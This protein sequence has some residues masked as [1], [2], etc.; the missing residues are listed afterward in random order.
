MKRLLLFALLL[1]PLTAQAQSP[2]DIF[3]QALRLERSQG[4]LSGAIKLYLQVATDFGGD[5]ALGA[6]ALYRIG[7]AYEQLGETEAKGAYQQIVAEFGDQ[8]ETVA[9]ARE[10]LGRLAVPV[11]G[12]TRYGIEPELVD[13]LFGY[14]GSRF[15]SDGRLF[16]GTN[17]DTNALGYQTVG[18][19]GVSYIT[20]AFED[21]ARNASSASSPRFSP[22]NQK[23]GFVWWDGEEGTHWLHVYD[24]R[25]G[26]TRVLFNNERRVGIEPGSG[27]AYFQ[28][29]DW[30]SD[31]SA[32]LME[33]W[34]KPVTGTVEVIDAATGAPLR[35]MSFDGTAVCLTGDRYVIANGRKAGRAVAVSLDLVSGSASELLAG[36][37][38]SN[39]VAC[40]D[41]GGL[42]VIQSE[43]TGDS[44]TSVHDLVEG[45]LGQRVSNVP[46]VLPDA[47]G[48]GLTADGTLH[49]Y[50][51]TGNR[52]LEA[53]PYSLETWT[54]SGPA[55][56]LTS[57]TG[58]VIGWAGESGAMAWNPSFFGSP[59]R[60]R[61]AEG[62]EWD[63]D[64]EGVLRY[65]PEGWTVAELSPDGSM[66]F[67]LTDEIA[68]QGMLRLSTTDGTVIDTV[69]VTQGTPGLRGDE[70]LG[71]RRQD[72]DTMC[73]D[74]YTGIPASSEE[75]VCFEDELSEVA[76]AYQ[77]PD[78]AYLLAYAQG[79]GG[80][81]YLRVSVETGEVKQILEDVRGRNPGWA[82]AGNQIFFTRDDRKRY[83]SDINGEN[84][85]LILPRLQE[86]R[87]ILQFTWHPT[88][89]F[90]MMDSIRRPNGDMAVPYRVGGLKALLTEDD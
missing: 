60:I 85:A 75:L 12:L 4:D 87:N 13:S 46:G 41:A 51:Q 53:Y 21:P 6:Q 26:E 88:Q 70:M 68:G 59:V 36:A 61:S 14:G 19:P 25:T 3:Q 73:I 23:I 65:S 50:R 34:T 64:V 18:V 15:S 80:R 10:A 90:V 77:S 78:G 38:E 79:E 32:I 28:I 57:G 45:R 76:W 72:D 9:M 7:Q 44:E 43:L 37:E 24:L 27:Y 81:R 71:G 82:P 84:V 48:L 42:A 47:A 39:V 17:W 63:I 62:T 67:A 33:T 35:E 74:V 11:T 16:V 83:R 56:R 58:G 20:P 54:V 52:R 55:E 86:T 8:S 69:A 31:G 22:D 49:Y 30:T 89:P 66:L 1:A 5:R 2:Q 40:S 29:Y